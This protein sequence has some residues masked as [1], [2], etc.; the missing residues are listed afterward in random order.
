LDRT[1]LKHYLL[2]PPQLSLSNHTLI[3]P[4]FFQR[5]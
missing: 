5:G 2:D 3:L 4:E 1:V